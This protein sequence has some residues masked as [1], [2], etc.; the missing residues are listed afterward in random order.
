MTRFE[1]M[2]R[3]SRQENM[4]V[5]EMWLLVEAEFKKVTEVTSPATINDKIQYHEKVG[6]CLSW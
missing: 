5:V 1:L 3:K 6:Y 4:V 2:V